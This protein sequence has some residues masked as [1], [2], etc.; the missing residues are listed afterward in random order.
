[1]FFPV[2]E[3]QVL[4]QRYIQ[5]GISDGVHVIVLQIAPIDFKYFIETAG[6]MKSKS[7]W[8][9]IFCL[10]LRISQPA[11]IGI[12]ELKFVSVMELLR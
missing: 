5:C 10:S 8:F 9:H 4:F 1:M 12:G 3:C 11:G 7:A 2:A 6:Q